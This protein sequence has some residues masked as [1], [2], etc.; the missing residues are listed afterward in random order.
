MPPPTPS[1]RARI[2]STAAR[3]FRRNGYTGTGLKQISADAGAPFGSIYHHFPGGKQQLAETVIRSTGR[4]YLDLV[5]GLLDGDP[6][7][8]AAVHRAFEAAATDLAAADYADACTIATVALE[9]AST[10][11]VLRVATADVFETWV[12][13]LAE[14]FGT[15]CDSGVARELAQSTIMIL[16]GAFVLSRASRDPEPLLVAGRSM[17]ALVRAA[18]DQAPPGRPDHG[19]VRSS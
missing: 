13:A 5:L 12:Q 18:V 6:D 3:L 7:P 4:E 2:E 15:W 19:H 10:D 9:V 8:A 1:N 14:W 16:E 11:E 17:A